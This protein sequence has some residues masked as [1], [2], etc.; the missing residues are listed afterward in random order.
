MECGK[1][2]SYNE[3]G[4]HKRFIN[5]GS[6]SFLCFQCLSKKL[7]V[8]EELIQEKIEHFKQQGCTLFV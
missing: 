2:L 4:V 3:I 5:R 1:H 6:T 7:D 8:S